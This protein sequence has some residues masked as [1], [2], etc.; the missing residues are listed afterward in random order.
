MFSYKIFT[1]DTK[2]LEVKEDYKPLET[3]LDKKIPV[4]VALLREETFSKI[5][6]IIRS[7]RGILYKECSSSTPKKRPLEQEISKL[8]ALIRQEKE[9]CEACGDHTLDNG[10]L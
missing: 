4:N 10:E 3:L 7:L 9:L 2:T 6:E 5:V 1:D 8:Q